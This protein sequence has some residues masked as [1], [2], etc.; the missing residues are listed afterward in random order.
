MASTEPRRPSTTLTV[1]R[2]LLA[3]GNAGKA[4]EIRAILDDIGWEIVTPAEAGVVVPAIVE[5]N[6]SYM[7][8]A[9]Q[10]A[11]AAAR[12]GDMPALAD[13]SGIEVDALG[14][15]PGVVSA[16]FGGPGVITDRERCELLLR[17]LEGVPAARRGARFR[18]VV[19][20]A[21]PG[22]RVITREGILE[23]RIATEPRGESGFG[24]DPVFLLPDGRS[25]AEI[26]DEKLQV[27]HR[28]RALAALRPV[29]AQLR[30]QMAR[31]TP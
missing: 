17:R 7:E 10:K 6:R 22:D 8:N 16:R 18:A 26:G 1:P 21:L 5:G 15:E 28:A 13:D 3:T 20:L 14:G 29:L 27:S 11:V 12:A 30:A 31:T 2:L 25:A 24:Y 19:A 23:G 9:V 4:R